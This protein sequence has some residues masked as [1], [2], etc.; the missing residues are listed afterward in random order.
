VTSSPTLGGAMLPNIYALTSSGL[1]AVYY[2]FAP[3][4]EGAA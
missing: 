2:G 1:L 4:N 3:N